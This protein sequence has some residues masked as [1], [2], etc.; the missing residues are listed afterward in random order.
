MFTGFTEDSLKEGGMGWNFIQDDGDYGGDGDNN[1]HRH[2]HNNSNLHLFSV[3]TLDFGIT[4]INTVY[5][6]Y[7]VK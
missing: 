6:L 5:I 3:F 7:E 1:N 2:H 4:Q